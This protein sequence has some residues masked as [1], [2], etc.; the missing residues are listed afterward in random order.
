MG[1]YPSWIRGYTPETPFFL[2]TRV[3]L[4]FF[5]QKIGLFI[6]ERN[7]FILLCAFLLLS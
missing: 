7:I 6:I 2:L 1:S 4:S 5:I 3:Y